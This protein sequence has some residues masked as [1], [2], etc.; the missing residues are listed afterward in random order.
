MMF[1][2]GM[3]VREKYPVPD[4]PGNLGEACAE[5][6]RSIILGHTAGDL[7]NFLLLGEGYVRHPKLENLK[8]WD[9]RDFSIDAGLALFMAAR[10]TRLSIFRGMQKD[11]WVFLFGTRRLLSIGCW[12]VL[13]E[14]WALL[15]TVNILQGKIMSLPFRW[16]DDTH[17]FEPMAGK[18]QDYLNMICICVFLKKI[19]APYKLPRPKE[20]CREAVRTYYLKGKDFEPNSAWMISIYDRELDSL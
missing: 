4:E 20:E 16:S 19:G 10:L 15:N 9:H 5:T 12:A 6:C 1:R 18:V 3:L 7:A 17:W 14:N 8:E 13:R 11:N 2:D